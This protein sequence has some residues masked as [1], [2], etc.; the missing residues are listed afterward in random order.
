MTFSGVMPTGTENSRPLN[1]L[2][3]F[4]AAWEEIT[5]NA[6]VQARHPLRHGASRQFDSIRP[7]F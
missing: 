1:D 6:R 5:G 3:L 2:P 4:P 7:E